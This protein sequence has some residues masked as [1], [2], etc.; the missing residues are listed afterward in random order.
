[1]NLYEDSPMYR[2]NQ[3]GSKGL[4]NAELIALA[5]GGEQHLETAHRLLQAMGGLRGMVS[6]STHKFQQVNGIGA[7]RAAQLVALMELARRLQNE[8]AT[9][10]GV[11]ATP[12]DAA[13]I[14]M[15][16]M[17]Y[18][19]Q[20][21]FVVM[22]MNTRGNVIA[23]HNLYQGSLNSSV[24]RVAE[25]FKLAIECNAAHIIVAHNHPS[26]DPVPSAEDIRMTRELVKAGKLLNIECR[27]HL[28]IGDGRFV[29]LRRDGHMEVFG[30]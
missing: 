21:N 7:K 10:L 24:V 16:G 2:L 14:L 28:V 11:V 18:L 13:G 30:I 4:S 26:G 15:P 19:T 12:E 20:E 29:S 1:M 23:L 5:L 17:R 22:C 3:V 6:S 8:C 27:D 25:V 9:H